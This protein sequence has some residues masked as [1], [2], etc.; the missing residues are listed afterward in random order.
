MFGIF[1]SWQQSNILNNKRERLWDDGGGVGKRYQ[2]V[3]LFLRIA[4]TIDLFF[5]ETTGAFLF[6]NYQF[7]LTT[8]L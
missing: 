8:T 1:S 3:P 7:Y 2:S 6:E 4:S 5:H